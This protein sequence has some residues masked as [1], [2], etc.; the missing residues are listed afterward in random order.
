M[1]HFTSITQLED[2]KEALK[3]AQYVKQNPFADQDPPD[4]FL[5][6]ESAH[7]TQHPEGCYESWHECDRS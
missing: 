1:R 6:F 3:E 2:L 5:Q 7:K 4:D